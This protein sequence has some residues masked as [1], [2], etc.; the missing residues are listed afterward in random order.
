MKK[1]LPL[2]L[3]L[4]TLVALLT[5]CGVENPTTTDVQ[6]TINPEVGA[7]GL[8]DYY[9]E[10]E[11]LVERDGGWHYK[12][13]H[14][15]YTGQDGDR[16]NLGTFDPETDTMA[17]Y[18][19]RYNWKMGD[20]GLPKGVLEDV[21]SWSTAKG[22]FGD[23][24]S[25]HE[26]DIGFAGDNHGLMICTTFEILDLEELLY[27][28][29]KLNLYCHYDNTVS[30]YL[31]G[32]LVYRHSIDETGTPDW[33]GDYECLNTYYEDV[34]AYFIGDD[35]M[36]QLLIEGKNTLFAMVKDAWGGR[37]LVLGLTCQ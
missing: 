21:S 19:E 8:D 4:A 31:N 9:G 26:S 16:V 13:F 5:A 1:W 20:R 7:D 12:L 23:D 11:I 33:N 27:T 22:P 10:K 15:Q 30:I 34:N 17:Q 36:K 3:V 18:M 14:M 29:E 2:L 35:A 28:Y 25:Y 37:V 6:P 24:G 32:T